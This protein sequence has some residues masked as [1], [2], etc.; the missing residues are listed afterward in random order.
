MNPRLFQTLMILAVLTAFQ[1]CSQSETSSV[2]DDTARKI[3]TKEEINGFEKMMSFVDNLI[4]DKTKMKDINDAYHA[5]FEK[6]EMS[7]GP[8]KDSVKYEFLETIDKAAF[9]AIWEMDDHAE[10]IT[11]KDSLLSNL[12]GFKTLGLNYRGKYRDY[13]KL[14]AETDSLYAVLNHS[15]EVAGDISPETFAWFL[16]HHREFDFTVFKNRLWAAVFILRMEDPLEE[17]V[18]RYF[19][20]ER[21]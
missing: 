6:G 7:P 14:T 19:K 18:E 12:D 21:Q 4:I 13:M 17:K 16:A 11:Y 1:N 10:F 15:I 2:P 20:I 3:F 5:Y 8:V 9:S